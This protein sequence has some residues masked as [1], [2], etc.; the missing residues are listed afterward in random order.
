[1][2]KSPK[3]LWAFSQA[4]PGWGKTQAVVSLVPTQLKRL[5]EHPDGVAWL[6]Q[7]ATDK[8]PGRIFQVQ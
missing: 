1:M 5:M 3:E 7:L 2:M 6:Q 4:L 8:H